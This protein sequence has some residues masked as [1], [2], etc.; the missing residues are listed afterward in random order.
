MAVLERRGRVPLGKNDVFAATVG[1]V[2][3]IDPAADLAVALAMATGTM[4]VPLPPDVVAFGE[5]GLAGEVRPVG[6]LSRRLN[7]AGRLGFRTALIPRHGEGEDLPK[8][9]SG[10]RIVQVGDIADML[11][12]LH[13][14]I[15]R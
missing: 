2:R 15:S 12:T 11:V 4:D 7:E 13:T 8:V 10:M 5:V 6:G 9:P 1:G 14:M 3:L